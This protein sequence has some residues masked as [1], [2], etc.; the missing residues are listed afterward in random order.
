MI[1]LILKKREAKKFQKKISKKENG[2][3]ILINQNI[4]IVAV[5]PLGRW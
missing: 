4:A 2:N 1:K 3:I 5:L